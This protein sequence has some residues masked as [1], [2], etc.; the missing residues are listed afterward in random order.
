MSSV[1]LKIRIIPIEAIACRATSFGFKIKI[2]TDFGKNTCLMDLN[3]QRTSLLKI[4]KTLSCFTFV[5]IKVFQSTAPRS[6]PM[7]EGVKI[8]KRFRRSIGL[9]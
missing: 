8:Q 4:K 5:V 6:L 3:F 2:E 1:N 7:V 9:D